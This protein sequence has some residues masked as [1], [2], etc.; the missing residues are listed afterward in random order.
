MKNK[1]FLCIVLVICITAVVIFKLLSNVLLSNLD[2]KSNKEESSE[3]TNNGTKIVKV[4]GEQYI[5]FLVEDYDKDLNY[6]WK[7]LK[8]TNTNNID[9]NLNLRLSIDAITNVTKKIN[10]EVNQK[11]LIIS[12]DYHGDLPEEAIIKLDVK[13]KF[14]NNDS[15]YLYYY[16]QDTDSIEFI[17]KDIIVKDG[18]VE[19]TIDHCS[20]YFLTGAIVNNAVNNPKLLNYI[21]IGLGAVAIILIGITLFKSKGD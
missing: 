17:E 11:K 21:I 19:F 16:N 1:Y 13:E 8:G 7:F 2:E 3:L 20:D 6:S 10:E 9:D 18:Y 12:F 4:E 15:L 5:S 14:K